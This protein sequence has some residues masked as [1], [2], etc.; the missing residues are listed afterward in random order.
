MQLFRSEEDLDRWCAAGHLSGARFSLQQLQHLAQAWYHNR[1]DLDFA[2][3]TV[4]D[5]VAI[6]QKVGLSGSF[7]EP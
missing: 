5:A 6:F 3:Y 4:A 1:L 7:W 2:G